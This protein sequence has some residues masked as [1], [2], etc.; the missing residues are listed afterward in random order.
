MVIKNNAHWA[1]I[2][3]AMINVVHAP[4]GTARRIG[5]DASYVIAGKTGTAQVFGIA[6][7]EEYDADV[8]PKHLQ[9]HALFVAYAPAENPKI[10]LAVVVEN[11]GSGSSAAAPVARKVLDAYLLEEHNLASR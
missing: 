8:I 3:Q 11:G 4:N 9:D 2:E 5:S 10:A 1:A 6:Q 7:D